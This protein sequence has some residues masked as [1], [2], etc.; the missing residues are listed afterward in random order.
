M[1]TFMD[2]LA[3]K[4]TAQ[5]MIKANMAAD[6]EEMDRLKKKVNEYSECLE[7]LQRMI[8]T[9]V[10]RLEGAQVDGSAIKRLV[11]EGIAKLDAAKVDGS[12]INRL[13][14][15]GIAKLDAAKVDG[16][17]I[18]HRIGSQLEESIAKINET[19]NNAEML[20][21][22]Q[23]LKKEIDE[24]LTANDE[25]V[26]KECVKVYRNVQAVVQE[27]NSKTID[28]V[29]SKFSKVRKRVNIVLG[30]TI[31]ALAFSLV[32]VV[33]QIVQLF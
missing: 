10:A 30:V 15:E 9:G 3:Q 7:Q 19:Q 6:A 33:L 13:V 1:D 5:E 14:E 21:L 12:E 8:D 32:S 24:K 16:D 28:V 2:K 11:E 23:A 29:C 20:E 31:A 26:H 25:N 22:L 17:E 27:E 18:G 4:L